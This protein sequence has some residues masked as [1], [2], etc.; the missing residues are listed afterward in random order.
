MGASV[1][2]RVPTKKYCIPYFLVSGRIVRQG[3][4]LNTIGSSLYGLCASD[5]AQMQPAVAYVGEAHARNV[6]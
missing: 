1:H 2:A 6:F 5:R 4:V 3:E